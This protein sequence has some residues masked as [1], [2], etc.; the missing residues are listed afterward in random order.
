M[1]RTWNMAH[2]LGK[3]SMVS[4][5]LSL[6]M[7]KEVIQI[8][9]DKYLIHFCEVPRVSKFIEMGSRRSSRG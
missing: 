9:K 5:G 1:E 6:L 2:S 3:P 7:L 4:L 8:Q